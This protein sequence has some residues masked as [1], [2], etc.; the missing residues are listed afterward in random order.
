MQVL[1]LCVL[2]AAAASSPLA[3]AQ[4]APPLSVTR[5]AGT[6]DCPDAAGLTARI[7]AIRNLAPTDQP[8]YLLTFERDDHGVHAQITSVQ[9]GAE[10]VLTDTSADCS[11]L[12]QATAITLALLF[13]ADA[14]APAGPAVLPASP[15]P[16]VPEEPPPAAPPSPSLRD[17]AELHRFIISYEA[18]ALTGVIAPVAA[19]LG[20]EIGYAYGSWR[21][22][23]GLLYALSQP[24]ELGNGSVLQSFAGGSLLGCFAPWR[25]ALWRLDACTGLVSATVEGKARGF[26]EVDQS[27]RGWLAPAIEA[28]FGLLPDRFGAELRAALLIPTTRHDFAVEGA[29]TAYRSTPVALLLSLR[30]GWSALQSAP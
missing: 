26:R 10:R 11:A 5:G 13:D 21:G 1:R 22:S 16:T 2:I 12:A 27:A 3:H 25:H 19:T 15:P 30:L 9:T 24:H 23:L 18:A 14:R 29:G 17:R 8:P 6:D 4:A 7:E 28:R 20:F